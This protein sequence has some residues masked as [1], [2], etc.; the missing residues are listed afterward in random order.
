MSGAEPDHRPLLDAVASLGK[1]EPARSR[2]L[3][4]RSGVLVTGDLVVVGTW[5]GDLIGFETATKSGDELVERWRRSFG[6]RP[7]TLTALEGRDELL[8][9]CR[10]D[11]GTIALVDVSDGSLRWQYDGADDVGAPSKDSVFYWPYAV[12]L[13][14]GDASDG[15]APAAFAAVRRYERRGEERTWHSVVLAFDHDGAVAWRYQTDASPIAI[16]H[17]RER[18]RI[19]VGYNRCFG[20]HQQGLVVLDAETGT[21]QWSWDPGVDGARR[22]GDVQFDPATGELA[23]ASHGDYCGYLVDADGTERWRVPLATETERGEETLYA[24]PLH[25]TVQNGRVA[26]VTGNTYAR[27]RRDPDGRHPDEHT[28][29]G[30]DTDGVRRWTVGVDGFVHDTASVDGRLVVSTAQNFRVREPDVHAVHAID[31]DDGSAETVS[32]EGIVTCVD[33]NGE[34]VAA[35]EAPVDYHDGPGPM[36]SY[37]LHAGS[38]DALR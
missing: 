26:F 11:H 4:R 12:D 32:A 25:A 3:F 18:G 5:T 30:V 22:V 38:L 37:A 27:E 14:S 9:G 29:F 21:R 10:G 35:I 34:R 13:A 20:D 24:Y 17:D 1:L 23:V 6:D 36:G 33:V 2:H 8:V 31:V 19:A 16:D 15:D 7:V 28:V